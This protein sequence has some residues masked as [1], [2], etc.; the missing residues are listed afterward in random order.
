MIRTL[1]HDQM[2]MVMSRINIPGS[3]DVTLSNADLDIYREVGR[4]I[5]KAATDPAEFNSLQQNT[6]QRLINEA[7]VPAAALGNLTFTLV[8]DDPQRLNLV[9]PEVKQELKGDALNAYLV[10]LGVVTIRACKH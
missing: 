9:I 10:E 1:Q 2:G 3:Q 7:G 4:L 8:K 5:Y 6:A